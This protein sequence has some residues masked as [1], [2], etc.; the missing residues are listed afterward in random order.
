M[1]MLSFDEIVVSIASKDPE[2][3]LIGD[4]NT[5]NSHDNIIIAL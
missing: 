4:G 1:V 5:V 3:E 2:K